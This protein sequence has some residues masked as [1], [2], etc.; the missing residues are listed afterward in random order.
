MKSGAGSC[1]PGLRKP[2]VDGCGDRPAAHA[3]GP[4][5]STV[6]R[7]PLMVWVDSLP[8]GQLTLI[9][10]TVAGT[11]TTGG[12]CERYPPPA[13]KS[14]IWVAPDGRTNVTRAPMA[15]GFPVLPGG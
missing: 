4:D 1:G 11:K 15:R 2:A 5:C 8:S 6:I 12:S 7:A 13:D 14:L 3:Y 9:L 10:L